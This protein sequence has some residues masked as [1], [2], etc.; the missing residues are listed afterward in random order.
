MNSALYEGWLSHSRSVDVSHGFR[1]R[2][3]MCYL[4]LDEVEAVMADH[5]LWSSRHVAPVRFQRADYLGGGGTALAEVAREIA[6][7]PENGPVRLLA[8]LRTWGWNFNPLSLYFCFDEFDEAV[9]KV[10]ASVTNTPWN[11]RHDYVLSAGPE[12]RVDA[13]VDK[14]LHVSPFLGME[15]THRFVISSPGEEL[16]VLVENYEHGER[17]FRASMRLSRR[18][19][20]RSAMSRL[21][22][23]F[24]FMTWRVSAGIYS[25]AARLAAKGAP[26][27]LHPNRVRPGASR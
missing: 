23:R 15:Q 10:I 7:T 14:A 16:R 13:A 24:P 9:R 11:E 17:V 19:L 6:G 8:N 12:G 2:I 3:A 27:H 18:D 25:Q 20:D 21:I 1:Y 22:V 4:D 26:F 5:P